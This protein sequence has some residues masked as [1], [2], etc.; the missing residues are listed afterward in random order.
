MKYQSC[1]AK[2]NDLRKRKFLNIFMLIFNQI[3][4]K[5][6]CF[7][8]TTCLLMNTIVFSQDSNSRLEKN[9][10]FTGA[11][12]KNHSFKVIYQL[13]SND[14]K[15]IQKTFRNINNSLKDPRLAGKLEAELITF[16]GGTEVMLKDSKYEDDLKALIEKGVIVGQCHNSLVERNISRDQIYDFVGVVPSGTGELILRQ[17][18]GWAIVKP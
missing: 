15:V 1:F 14:P 5:H 10:T 2:K 16:S 6:L 17:A 11:T 18:Q 8:F 13:D 4:M 7:L 9:K 3:P 12:S